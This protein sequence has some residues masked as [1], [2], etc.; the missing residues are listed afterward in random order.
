[1]TTEK[2][3][4]GND[5]TITEKLSKLPLEAWESEFPMMELCLKD[6]IRLQLHGTGFRKNKSGKDISIGNGE[7][8][9]PDAFMVLSTLQLRSWIPS[10]HVYRYITS[11]YT[12]RTLSISLIL[13]YGIPRVI[14]RI[15]PRTRSHH[16][17]ILVGEQAVI[18]AW[19]CDL[20]S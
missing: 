15:V 9:P 12:I 7:V 19:E 14:F 17:L 4:P 1:M 5:M 18:P 11:A 6:S 8:I 10:S 16:M 3:F 2:Y 13:N 20:P